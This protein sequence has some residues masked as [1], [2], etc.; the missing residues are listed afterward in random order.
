MVKY[1][2]HTKVFRGECQLLKVQSKYYICMYVWN[3]IIG[4]LGVRSVHYTKVVPL[5][6]EE[7]ICPTVYV[8]IVPNHICFY[9]HSYLW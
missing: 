5:I 6:C 1:E 9:I 2:L 8:W 7:Y 3:F 4:L